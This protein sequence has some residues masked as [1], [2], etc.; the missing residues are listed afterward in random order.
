MTVAIGVLIE[1][2]RRGGARGRVA[3]RRLE[4]MGRKA[5]RALCVAYDSPEEHFRWE[6]VNLLGYTRDPRAIPLLC[7][8]GIHDPEIHPRW[9]S[10][11]ALTSVDDGT[12][13]AILRRQIRRE[14]GV[15]RR[16]AAVAL[17]LYR[18]PAALAVLRRG[19]GSRSGWIRWESASCLAGYADARSSARI[20]ELYGREKDPSVRKEMVRAVEGVADRRVE[21]FLRRR[22]SSLQP[23]IREVAA[24]ALMQTF[25]ERSVT[26]LQKRLE[27]E[28]DP[29]V[30]NTMRAALRVRR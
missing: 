9:R 19:L 2:L 21:R 22:L 28:P 4:Q 16:H 8:R 3:S 26:A 18:D 25:G 14:R 11:W 17:S 7:R 15:R 20:L 27:R 30:R 1:Q 5:T 29:A 10:I 23:E 6:I 13:T 12:V 24:S